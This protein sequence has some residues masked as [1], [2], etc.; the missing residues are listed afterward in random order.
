[1]HVRLASPATS[2]ASLHCGISTCLTAF[3]ILRGRWVNKR[4][5]LLKHIG[6]EDVDWINL[7]EDRVQC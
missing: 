3:P 7:G 1:M 4:T 5:Y 6:W 2:L